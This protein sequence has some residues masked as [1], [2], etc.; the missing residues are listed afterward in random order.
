MSHS[1]LQ[2]RVAPACDLGTDPDNVSKGATKANLNGMQ[3]P[4]SV[5]S[6]KAFPAHEGEQKTRI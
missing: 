1:R 4:C 2:R 5:D 3:P 6:G